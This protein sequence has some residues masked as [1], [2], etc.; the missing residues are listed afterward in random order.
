[1]VLD[2]VEV[3]KTGLV[4]AGKGENIDPVDEDSALLDKDDGTE[5]FESE[6]RDCEQLTHFCSRLQSEETCPTV[7]HLEHVNCPRQTV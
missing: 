1:M 4:S 7:A 3:S 5:S 2:V 6:E